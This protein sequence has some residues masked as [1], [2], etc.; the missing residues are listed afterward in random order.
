MGSV[1]PASATPLQPQLRRS[2]FLHQHLLLFRLLIAIR[3]AT[4]SFL[5]QA[6]RTASH[7]KS[8]HKHKCHEPRTPHSRL[9]NFTLQP[10]PHSIVGRSASCGWI[11]IQ[12]PPKTDARVQVLQREKVR[13]RS[14][15]VTP[16]SRVWDCTCRPRL[17]D[18][19]T[20]FPSG[21]CR[22]FRSGYQKNHRSMDVT[23]R[24]LNS[25]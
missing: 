9:Q 20:I 8:V 18:L 11:N 21:R 17:L 12:T 1:N 24:T 2:A 14:S 16:P 19:P 6:R 22:S 13:L 3:I 4:S 15:K 23:G 7:V 25:I 10:P 5:G